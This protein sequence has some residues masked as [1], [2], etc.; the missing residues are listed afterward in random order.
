MPLVPGRLRCNDL[1]LGNEL[2]CKGVDVA[3]GRLDQ[4]MRCLRAR[5]VSLIFDNTFVDRIARQTLEHIGQLH[6]RRHTK[7]LAEILSLEITEQN[8]YPCDDPFAV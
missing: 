5:P 7:R 1:W 2:F 8:R 3:D 4:L 6:K